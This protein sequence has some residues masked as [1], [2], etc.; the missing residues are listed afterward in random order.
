MWCAVFRYCLA[1]KQT[2]LLLEIIFFIV[3]FCYDREGDMIDTL[4]SFIFLDY[5]IQHLVGLEI[6]AKVGKMFYV[7][8][9]HLSNLEVLQHKSYEHTAEFQHKCD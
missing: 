5:C 7:V 6:F 8:K 9:I 4:S 2:T 3:V 1:G